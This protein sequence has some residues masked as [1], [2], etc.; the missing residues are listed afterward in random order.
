MVDNRVTPR[1]DPDPPH[2]S[3][4][5]PPRLTLDSEFTA[6]TPWAGHRPDLVQDIVYGGQRTGGRNEDS[7][8]VWDQGGSP[9]SRASCGRAHLLR[10]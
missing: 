9:W 3:P 2:L 4:P 1:I 6:R 8:R 7:E 5:S 10:F